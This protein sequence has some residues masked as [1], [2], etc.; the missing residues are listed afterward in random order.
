MGDRRR[1]EIL[2]FCYKSS[3]ESRAGYIVGRLR[4]GLELR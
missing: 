2:Y 1:G 4:T 3:D